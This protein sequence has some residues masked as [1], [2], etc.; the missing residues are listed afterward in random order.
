MTHIFGPR[1]GGWRIGR[2]VMPRSLGWLVVAAIAGFVSVVCASGASAASPETPNPPGP[3]CPGCINDVNFGWAEHID[4]SFHEPAVAMAD[5]SD[6]GIR[7]V[8]AYVGNDNRIHYR[9]GRLAGAGIEWNTPA[10]LLR[11]Y[12]VMPG[13]KARLDVAINR[14]GQVVFSF[15]AAQKCSPTYGGQ[16]LLAGHLRNDGVISL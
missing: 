7:I 16:L 2:V 1:P 9:A 14:H 3:T 5:V 15:R 11:H 10:V 4:T 12:T 8:A 13:E 6:Q